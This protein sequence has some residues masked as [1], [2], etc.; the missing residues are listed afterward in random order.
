MKNTSFYSNTYHCHSSC[1]DPD[2]HRY[3]SNDCFVQKV[4]WFNVLFNRRFIIVF[5]HYLYQF[6]EIVYQR[7]SLHVIYICMIHVRCHPPYMLFTTLR[8]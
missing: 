6:N 7:S 2:S 8:L 5:Y 4:K 3:I 1:D